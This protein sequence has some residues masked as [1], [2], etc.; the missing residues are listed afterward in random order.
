MIFKSEDQD[1]WVT[2]YWWRKKG[3]HIK[4]L[5]GKFNKRSVEKPRIKWEDMVQ[6]SALRILGIRRWRKRAGDTEEWRRF[7]R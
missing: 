5:M 7:S 4:V 3:S 1:V 2:S 6:K